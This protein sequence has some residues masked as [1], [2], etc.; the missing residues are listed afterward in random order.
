MVVI[1]PP[2]PWNRRR[3]AGHHGVA[4]A[5]GVLPADSTPPRPRPLLEG[6]AGV[7]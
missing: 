7:L 6:R 5:R 3:P 4:A 2:S 1:A